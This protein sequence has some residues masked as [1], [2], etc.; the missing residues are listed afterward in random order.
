MRISDVLP[1]PF[2]P[3]TASSS[4]ALE[5]EAEP[6]EQ[7]A[8]TEPQR[9]VVDCD[10]AHRREGGRERAGLVELPLLEGQVRRQRLGH[11]HDGD[12]G[13]AAPRARS[14]AVIGETACAV[15]EEH[16]DAVLARRASFMAATA[17]A[18]GS[19]PSSIGRVNE[20]GARFRSPAA[21]TR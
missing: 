3:S 8:V 21:A 5:L 9:E 12:P 1:V 10:D 13:L 17:E 2:G 6:F 15:V 19:V 14:R 7:R 16:P 18:D 11:R 4:P 20:S